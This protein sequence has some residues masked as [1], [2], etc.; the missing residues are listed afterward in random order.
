MR[1]HFSN[2]AE[3]ISLDVILKL[4]VWYLYPSQRHS[5]DKPV[6]TWYLLCRDM[7]RSLVYLAV[8]NITISISWRA[9]GTS[10]LDFRDVMPV[11]LEANIS[12]V[13]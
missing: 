1:S 13:S 6:D 3:S 2:L 9:Q 12:Q 8:F 7:S 5:L 4:F 10:L 11:L